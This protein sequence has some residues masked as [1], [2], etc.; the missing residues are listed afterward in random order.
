[1]SNEN[2]L[3]K[4]CLFLKAKITEVFHD[5]TNQIVLPSVYVESENKNQ[6]LNSMIYSQVSSTS[7]YNREAV[8]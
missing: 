8:R 3:L 7:M 4:T 5:Y 6:R 2:F 1:M